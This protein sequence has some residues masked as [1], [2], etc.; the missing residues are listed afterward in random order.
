M[1]PLARVKQCPPGWKVGHESLPLVADRLRPTQPVERA[2]NWLAARPDPGVALRVSRRSPERAHRGGVKHGVR[3][4]RRHQDRRLAAHPTRRESRL[5]PRLDPRLANDLVGL[6]RHARACRAQYQAH[7]AR[8]R[9]RHPRHAHRSGD[10]ALDRLD[11]PNRPGPRLSRH[12]HRPHG[13][14]R[15]GHGS[16]EDPRVPRIPPRRPH[17]AARRGGRRT[18]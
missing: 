16:D 18:R 11:Q 5:R 1:A 4:L 15:H 13:D 9:R 17:A 7:Q 14:A 10:R 2:S 8:H 12:R 6:L 3:S